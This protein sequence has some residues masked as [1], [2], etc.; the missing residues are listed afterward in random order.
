MKK[1]MKDIREIVKIA[2]EY[3]ATYGRTDKFIQLEDK[4]IAT[5]KAENI[6]IFARDV[7]DAYIGKFCDGIISTENAEYIFCFARDVKDA[8]IAKLGDGIILTRNAEWIYKFAHCINGANKYKLA[9]AMRAIGDN[10]WIEKFKENIGKEYI[11]DIEEE[12]DYII[13]SL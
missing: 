6:Y 10:K 2:N 11:I 12:L 9:G 3:Y 7:Q 1:K 4:I 8:D 13:K 5:K